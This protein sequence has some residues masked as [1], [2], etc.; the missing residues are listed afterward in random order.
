VQDEVV[1]LAVLAVSESPPVVRVS[2]DLR[3]R[4]AD[5]GGRLAA[6]DE[7]QERGLGIPPGEVTQELRE[8]VPD[9]LGAFPDLA[10]GDEDVAVVGPDE[11][12]G[13]AGRVDMP[14]AEALCRRAADNGDTEALP[15]LAR[16]REKTGDAGGAE[17][18]YRQAIDAGDPSAAKDLIRLGNAGRDPAAAS[19]LS[20]Y[21]LD[22]DRA[23][24]QSPVGRPLPVETVLAAAVAPGP[25]LAGM[26]GQPSHGFRPI[27]T[28]LPLFVIHLSQGAGG[29]LRGNDG[30]SG[31]PEGCDGYRSS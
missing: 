6:A 1:A 20:R 18:L 14:G 28:C 16:L 4:F 12:V 31:D 5:D 15:L 19:R 7:E 22:P 30:V 21:G 13:P 29:C 2:L 10:L 11:D 27:H 8:G 26:N 17:I 24:A 23:I 3:D 25:G 9:G